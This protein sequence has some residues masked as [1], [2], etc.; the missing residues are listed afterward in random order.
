MHLAPS[1]LDGGGAQLALEVQ[2]R[3]G[4]GWKGRA[5][6]EGGHEGVRR[7]AVHAEVEIKDW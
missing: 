5:L 4:R 6:S 2:L 7:R 1:P 3:R